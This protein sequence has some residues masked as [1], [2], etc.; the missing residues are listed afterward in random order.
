MNTFVI[1]REKIK[2]NAEVI[3]SRAGAA[4]VIAVVKGRGYGFGLDEYVSLLHECGVRFFAVTEPSDALAVGKL[5][6]PDTD[7]LMLRSTA[8]TDE[9]TALIENDIILTVGS[10]ETA[11][12][13]NNIASEKK[14]R[15]RVHIKIDTGMGRYGFAPTDVDGIA[16]AFTRF[17]SL[18]PC[19][20]F[21]HLSCAFNDEKFTKRQV[22]T[23]LKLQKT[24]SER[25]IDCGMVHFS[26]SSY[27]FNFGSPLGDAVRV[28]SA[29]TGRIACKGISTGLSRVGHLEGNICE[30]RTLTPG[31]KVGYGKT[32][33]TKINTK[34]A[35]VPIGYS[36]G[37]GVEKARDSYRFRDGLM[38]AA[39][40]LKRMLSKKAIYVTVNDKCARVLGH[41]GMTHTVC[42]VTDIRCSVGDTVKFD[43]NPIYVSPDI[44]REFI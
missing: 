24:L 33:T 20:M 12:V 3:F 16:S 8:L 7:I 23:F 13:I 22:D 39:M 11:S 41:I 36:D 1:E 6:L 15:A 40:E 34:I 28:G 17:E 44:Y 29:F 31:S 35:I 37:F 42:D 18:S 5:N 43:V 2:K 4:S 32:Y 9:V 26:N 21:T 25:N 10:S 38:Y 30:I 27:L 14:K 19:G